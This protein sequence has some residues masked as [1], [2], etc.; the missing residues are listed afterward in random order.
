VERQINNVDEK[1]A[2]Y[3]KNLKHAK[4]MYVL[5]NNGTTEYP[6]YVFQTTRAMSGFAELDCQLLGGFTYNKNSKEQ[7]KF[8]KEQG[9]TIIGDLAYDI[10]PLMNLCEFDKHLGE[11]KVITKAECAMFLEKQ[12]HH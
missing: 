7:E 6:I 1:L 11:F 3:K 8:M 5:V 4:E 9:Y 2:F 10:A 12:R